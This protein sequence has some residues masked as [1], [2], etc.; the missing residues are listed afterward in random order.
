MALT[1]KQ[2]IEKLEKVEDKEKDVYFETPDN[3]WSIDHVF[4][5]EGEDII[6]TNDIKSEHC[7]CEYCNEH[8]KEIWVIENWQTEKI[9]L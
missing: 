7:E 8:V 3:F 9:G 1:I 5:D 4:F 2:L 6:F